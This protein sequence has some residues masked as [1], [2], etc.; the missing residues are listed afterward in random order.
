MVCQNRAVCVL[1]ILELTWRIGV[2]WMVFRHLMVLLQ[3]P[4]VP[5]GQAFHYPYIFM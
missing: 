5:Q 2:H 1:R 3:Q 4:R